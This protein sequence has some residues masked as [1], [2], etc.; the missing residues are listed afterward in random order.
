VNH[1]DKIYNV[2]AREQEYKISSRPDL[3]IGE[4]GHVYIMEGTMN[5]RFQIFLYLPTASTIS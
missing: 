1:R 4:V 3:T 5:Q 2:R